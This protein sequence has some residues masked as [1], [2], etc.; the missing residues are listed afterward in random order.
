M[1]FFRFIRY[2]GLFAVYALGCLNNPYVTYRKLALEQKSQYHAL[3]VAGFAVLYFAFASFIRI[4]K[5][6]PFLLT[7]HFYVLIF[8][9]LICF[10]VMVASMYGIGKLLGS[11][12]SLKT[13]AILW[14]YSLL[15]TITWFF[16][17][18]ILFLL[19]PP[20]RSEALSGKVF[21][22]VFLTLTLALLFWKL[23]LY[24]LTL[25]FALRVDLYKIGIITG[26]I[27]PVVFGLS[28]FFYSMHIFRIP[29]L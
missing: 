20:P 24:Y 27:L 3:F 10:F 22:I 11:K 8:S 28:I 29:F 7:F 12:G 18:S 23:I 9:S 4:G 26:F 6:Y 25:R 21:S 1:V 2:A 5:S 14:L 17:T 15:P 19:L 13:V 16:L